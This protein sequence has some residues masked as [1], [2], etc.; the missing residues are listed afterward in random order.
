MVTHPIYVRRES[1][2]GANQKL[3]AKAAAHNRDAAQLENHVNELLQKQDEPIKVYLWHEIAQGVGLSYDT[4]AKLGYSIDG[5]SNGFTAIK[6]GMTY[7]QAMVTID[8]HK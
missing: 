3:R 7:E 8:Q 2:R 6:A 5:G 1:Y 4:V